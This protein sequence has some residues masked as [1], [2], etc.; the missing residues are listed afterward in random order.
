MT[1]IEG[2]CLCGKIRYK[3]AAEP[4]ATVLCNCI[5]CQ[6]QGGGAYS[7]NIVLPRG[8]TGNPG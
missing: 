3:S 2:G 7:V 5:N 4:L 8:F 1:K 6:K